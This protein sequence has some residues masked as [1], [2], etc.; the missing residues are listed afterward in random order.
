DGATLSDSGRIYLEGLLDREKK[1]L[2]NS[3]QFAV[4][5]Y[6]SDLL[7]DDYYYKIDSEN[8]F[9]GYIAKT[10]TCEDGTPVITERYKE[11]YDAILAECLEIIEKNS[12]AAE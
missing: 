10:K 2:K 6:S 1:T 9:S 4:A 3:T 11:K 7:W 12:K 5:P 8:W